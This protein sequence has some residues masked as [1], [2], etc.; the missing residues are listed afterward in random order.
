MPG[1]LTERLKLLPLSQASCAVAAADGVGLGRTL[2]VAVAAGWPPEHF[3]D[4]A[5]AWLGAKLAAGET[6]E[7][8]LYF[9][10]LGAS[11]K[12]A[13]PLVIGTAGYKGPPDRTGAVEVGYSILPQ[14][15]RRGYASEAVRALI[16]RAFADPRVTRVCAET[17]PELA[18][19]LRVMEKCGLVFVGPGQ[20]PRAVHYE[21]TRADWETQRA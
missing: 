16:A 19:S 12:P 7:W 13:D 1:M 5:L 8:L 4:G 3:D 18:P 21:L 10:V 11:G 14:F 9:V 17:F 2:G 15:Q 6:A 20:E